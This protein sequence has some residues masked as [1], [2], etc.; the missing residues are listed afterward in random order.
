VHLHKIV[1][2]YMSRDLHRIGDVFWLMTKVLDRCQHAEVRRISALFSASCVECVAHYYEALI[3][4]DASLRN[5]IAAVRAFAG[6]TLGPSRLVETFAALFFCRARLSLLARNGKDVQCAR[7]ALDA[8]EL[9]P[10]VCLHPLTFLGPDGTERVSL[11]AESPA[12]V[13]FDVFVSTTDLAEESQTGDESPDRETKSQTRILL[14][15][16]EEECSEV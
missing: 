16:L 11:A 14:S 8:A 10:Q 15:L 1:S 3:P 9:L 6:G 4:E 5:M 12:H 13:A 7:M 2:W